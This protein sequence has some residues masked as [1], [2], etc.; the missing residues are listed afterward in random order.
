LNGHQLVAIGLAPVLLAQG[1]YVRLVT[2]RLPEPPGERRGVR[3]IGP[4]L[5]L[6]IAGDSAAAGVGADTQAS[7]LSG[8]LAANLAPHFCI[9]WQLV[10]K[11]GNTIRDAIDQLDA[12]PPETFDVAVVS[13]GVNDVVSRTRSGDW[14]ERQRRLVELLERKHGVHQIL[15]SA[16]PPMQAFPA[17]P[18]PLAWYLGA[19]AQY[20]NRVSSGWCRQSGRCEFVQLS[21]PLQNDFIAADGFHPG[22][23]AYSLW[24]AHLAGLIQAR[25]LRDESLAATPMA[26]PH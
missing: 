12:E 8:R 7:G 19:R 14:L 4:P 21:F 6:L 24:A 17:L 26:Q 15:F 3:G 2:P 13:V 1:L 16:I 18:N 9:A 11:T 10:A 5:R 20:L 25:F 23:A 22:P